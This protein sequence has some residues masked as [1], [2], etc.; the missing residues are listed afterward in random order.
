MPTLFHVQQGWHLLKANY[1]IKDTDGNDVYNVKGTNFTWGIQNTLYDKEGTELASIKQTK[2]MTLH[3]KFEVIRDGKKWAECS[4]E[5]MIGFKEKEALLN[6]PGDNNYMIKG[7][8]FAVGFEIHR[9]ETGKLAATVNK[10]VGVRDHYAVSVEDGEDIVA[11]II[12][13]ALIDGIYHSIDNGEGA[14]INNMIPA[15]VKG[16]DPHA[17]DKAS[18]K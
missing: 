6:I 13:F 16:K 14:L 5:N 17:S 8:K 18:N 1:W 10:E 2:V 7:D 9:T 11:C 4:K 15:F 12:C 3:P